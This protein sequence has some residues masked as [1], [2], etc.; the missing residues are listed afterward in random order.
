MSENDYSRFDL[1]I[2]A[3]MDS[4]EEEVPGRVWESV[5][6]RLDS[7]GASSGTGKA[8]F[9]VWLRRSLAGVAVAAAVVSA[10]ILIP[11]GGSGS[12][13]S[14]EELLAVVPSQGALADVPGEIPSVGM[15]EFR[16]SGTPSVAGLSGEVLPPEPSA[17]SSDLPLSESGSAGRNLSSDESDSSLPESVSEESI[18][19]ASVSEASVSEESISEASVSE[20]SLSETSVSE[21]PVS[22]E[23]SENPAGNPSEVSPELKG[24]G[25][26]DVDDSDWVDARELEDRK[27]IRSSLSISG[28]AMTNTLSGGMSRNATQSYSRPGTPSL[29][30]EQVALKTITETGSS[31]YGIPVSFG[32]GAKFFIGRRW[33]IGAGLNYTIM[34]RSFNGIYIDPA[35]SSSS[36]LSYDFNETK[37]R[38][39]VSYIGIPINA[40]FSIIRTN[41]VDFYVYAGGSA[42]KCVANVYRMQDPVASYKENVNGFQFSVGAGLGVEFV[43]ADILGIYADP[44]VRYYFKDANQPKSIRTENPVSFGFELGLRIRL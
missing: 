29:G 36:G 38:N 15:E 32:I 1:E 27:K 12:V 9:P 30:S 14:G 18:S 25:N 23:P 28:N 35:T 5:C 31:S 13:E 44:S 33:A 22:A 40:Y 19:E 39:S 2:K 7:A 42:E 24:A 20:E 4:A 16:P 26:A 37:I 11:W 3:L 21:E 34:T 8:V 17:E 10:V 43:V 41:I 6:E